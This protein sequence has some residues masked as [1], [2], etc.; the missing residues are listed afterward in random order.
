MI[1]SYKSRKLLCA[2]ALFVVAT[3][4]VFIGQ[5]D[6]N[7]WSDF[8]KWVFGIYAAGNVGAY[9]ANKK[10]FVQTAPGVIIAQDNVAAK[11]GPESQDTVMPISPNSPF[12]VRSPHP[13]KKK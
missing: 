6:F 4:F 7:G 12:Q 1:P 3:V 5:T 8:V 10:E 9:V 11:M 2:L 13:D